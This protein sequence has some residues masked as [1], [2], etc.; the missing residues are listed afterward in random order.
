MTRELEYMLLHI[1]RLLTQ[2]FEGTSAIVNSLFMLL[3]GIKLARLSFLQAYITLDDFKFKRLNASV[4]ID[5]VYFLLLLLN[6]HLL[7]IQPILVEL[8][9]ANFLLISLQICLSHLL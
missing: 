5:A 1:S 2:L 7:S 3:Y 8:C 9:S 4:L 6:G